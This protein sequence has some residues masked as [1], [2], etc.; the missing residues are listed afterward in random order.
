MVNYLHGK[1]SS[2]Q[3]LSPSVPFS[4]RGVLLRKERGIYITEPSVVDPTLLAAVI[5]LN[6]GA[7]FTMSTQTTIVIGSTLQSHE[8]D[9]LLPDG[10]QVQVIDSLNDIVHSGSGLVKKFQYCA[11][12]RQEQ[13]LLVW[14]D[15]LDCILTKAT[16]IED[17][18]L[19][20]VSHTHWLFLMS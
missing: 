7:A 3:W 8:T 20:L 15:D 1:I 5:K 13:M 4:P 14:H 2:H 18:L 19:G 16:E 6:V 11:F 9:I 10:R 17:K 12:L